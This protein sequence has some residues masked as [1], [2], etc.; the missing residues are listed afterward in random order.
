MTRHVIIGGGPVATNAI[1]SIRE[2]GGADDEIV[3]ICDE[4]AHSR[5]ALPYWLAGQIDVEHTYTSDEQHFGTNNVD[6]KIGCRATALN[7]SEKTVSLDNG[8]TVSYDNLLI[9]T[10]ASPL[11][12]PI[13]GTDLPGVQALW[14][15]EQTKALLDQ[16]QSIERPKV[17]MIG[18]GFIGFIMLNAMY[19]RGW[20][21]SVVERESH[22]L[23]RMMDADAAS[24]VEGWLSAKGIGL[25][26][27][28]SCSRITKEGDHNRVH[29]SDGQTIDADIVIIATGIQ[30]NLGL[31]DGTAIDVDQGIVVDHHLKT[32]VDGIYAGGDCAQGPV[33]LSSH[34]AIH[35]IQPTAVDH[36]R[37]AG[38]N[39]AG[40][41]LE[42][43]GSL[44]MNVLDCC[45]LQCAS[46]GRWDDAGNDHTTIANASDSVFRRF[47]WEGDH[48]V[49]AIF[50]GQAN[51]VGMLTDVGMVK[52]ILQTGGELGKWRPY[53]EENPFDVRRVFVAT[54]VANKLIKSTLLGQPTKARDYQGGGA[55]TPAKAGPGHASY[56]GTKD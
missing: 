22:V 7:P 6:A 45:G 48:L 46:F 33:M 50:C 10:G 9:A 47:V 51:D 53:L 54:G 17:V 56:I 41:Q 20:D 39:M 19:K 18:A 25:H 30:P 34:K 49:G 36:G 5:M 43:S 44:L 52:G 14:T 4:P 26:C 42:Y 21:L 37:I 29:L 1:Q 32:S 23:P 13:D 15:I 35:A 28:A 27:G 3:L 8:E 24:V 55:I 40:K 2:L 11:A 12:L 38:A 16:C 31:T